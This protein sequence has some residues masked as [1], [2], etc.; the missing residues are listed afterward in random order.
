L[1]QA[2]VS[3]AMG[4]A[5]RFAHWMADVDCRSPIISHFK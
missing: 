5:A 2:G 4:A 3:R 1:A